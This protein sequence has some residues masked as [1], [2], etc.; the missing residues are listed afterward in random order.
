M[1]LKPIF[2][3]AMLTEK[4]FKNMS[5]NQLILLVKDMLEQ[6]EKENPGLIDSVLRR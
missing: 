2:K 5:N 4:D 6:Y 3:A 1:E